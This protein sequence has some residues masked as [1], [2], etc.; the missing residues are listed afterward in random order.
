VTRNVNIKDKNFYHVKVNILTYLIN[1]LI[2]C[3]IF[4]SNKELLNK[5]RISKIIDKRKLVCFSASHKTCV[6]GG[7]SRNKQVLWAG[8]C[9]MKMDI[10]GY[11]SSLL[12]GEYTSC[13]DF[14]LFPLSHLL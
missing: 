14:I 5:N 7:D 1:K 12:H 10:K 2:G 6:R 9:T 8:S 13:H 3:I 4:R 11:Q